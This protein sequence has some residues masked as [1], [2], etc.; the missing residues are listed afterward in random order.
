MKKEDVEINKWYVMECYGFRYRVFV[1]ELNKWGDTI[2]GPYQAFEPKTK[3]YTPLIGSR[4]TPGGFGGATLK[5]I[6]PCR[7][8][9]K[10]PKIPK[11]RL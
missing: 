7:K 3:K 9:S 8:G 6:T 11:E 1:T 5:N 4:R 2:T 10:L